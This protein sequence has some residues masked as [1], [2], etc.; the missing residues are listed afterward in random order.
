MIK[1]N[2]ILNNKA[3]YRYLK[4]PNS[5][6]ER[7]IKNINKKLKLFKKNEIFLTILLSSDNEIKKLN[8]KFRKKNYSTDVLSFPFYK[9]VPA[10]KV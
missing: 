8:K 4:N 5:F 1:I 9:N 6:I 7:K 2:T 3:W 10:P